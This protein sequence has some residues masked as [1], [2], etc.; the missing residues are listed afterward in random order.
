M[1]LARC[2]YKYKKI[3]ID[4]IEYE[5]DNKTNTVNGSDSSRVSANNF[6]GNNKLTRQFKVLNGEL[7]EDIDLMSSEYWRMVDAETFLILEENAKAEKIQ[8]IEECKA[9]LLATDYKVLPDYDKTDGIQ[10]IIAKRQQARDTIRAL[11][12]E[13]L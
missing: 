6:L 4:N 1:S 12:L 11:E 7:W 3:S 10:E 5:L 8:T 9:Y 2:L 13:L